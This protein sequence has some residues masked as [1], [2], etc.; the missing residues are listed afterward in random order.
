MVEEERD[1]NWKWGVLAGTIMEILDMINSKR[2]NAWQFA[3]D[4]ENLV[5]RDVVEEALENEG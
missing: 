3:R 2:F 5:T 1:I 4:V